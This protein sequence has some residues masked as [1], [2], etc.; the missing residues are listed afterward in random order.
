MPLN[1]LIGERVD[2]LDPIFQVVP[3]AKWREQTRL[4]T[5]VRREVG[6]KFK[7]EIDVQEPIWLAALGHAQI[8]FL[9][10]GADP[11]H[12]SYDVICQEHIRDRVV[13]FIFCAKING[14]EKYVIAPFALSEQ[15][16][17]DLKV[18]GLWR[19]LVEH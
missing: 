5:T 10:E 2:G 7:R 8:A 4:T 16:V 9:K 6:K 15:Q 18:R 11:T 14:V 3:V 17:A 1:H 12:L 19:D 13:C